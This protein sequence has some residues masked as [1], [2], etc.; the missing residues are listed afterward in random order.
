MLPEWLSSCY[1]NLN[2]DIQDMEAGQ[3]K[4]RILKRLEEFPGS[5]EG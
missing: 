5:S 4:R 2:G 1:T 3:E